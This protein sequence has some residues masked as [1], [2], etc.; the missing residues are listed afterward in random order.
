[1]QQCCSLFERS[2]IDLPRIL[3]VAFALVTWIN[4]HHVTNGVLFVQSLFLGL[5]V[6][7]FEENH[8]NKLPNERREKNIEQICAVLV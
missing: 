6:V 3:V 5:P 4:V 7:H 1:M 2:Q 8:G